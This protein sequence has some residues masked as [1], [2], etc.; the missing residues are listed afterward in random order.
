MKS[1]R[2]TSRRDRRKTSRRARQ[3]HEGPDRTLL[4]TLG[5]FVAVSLVLLVLIAFALQP[6]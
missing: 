2:P 6:G 3:R 1:G 5:I 4:I